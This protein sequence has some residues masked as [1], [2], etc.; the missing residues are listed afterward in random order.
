MSATAL[1]EL[2]HVARSYGPCLVFRD[3]T[4][5]IEHPETVGIIGPNGAGK[6]TLL[7]IIVGLLRASRGRVLFEGQLW[8]ST[9]SPFA[10]AYFGGESTLPPGVSARKWASLFGVRAAIGGES[11]AM[12]VLSRGTRQLVGLRTILARG[13]PRLVV[14]DEPWEGLDPDGSRWL[15]GVLRQRRAAGVSIIVS[16]HRLHDLAGLCDR[17]AFFAHQSLV[18]MSASE[19]ETAGEIT[20]ERLLAVFDT[21]RRGSA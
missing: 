8:P 16:S 19:L 21:L 3:V 20:G 17:Y 18:C 12:R 11:R 7:R 1:V 2:E 15:S 4:L 5:S 6:T 9:H 14:L 10:L 13:E